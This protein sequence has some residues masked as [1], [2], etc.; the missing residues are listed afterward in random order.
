MLDRKELAA[1]RNKAACAWQESKYA[2]SPDPELEKWW[3]QLSVTAEKIYFRLLEGKAQ[4]SP[5]T[6]IWYV[7]GEAV[8]MPNVCLQRKNDAEV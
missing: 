5:S 4:E 2:G 8:E 1:I 6:T 7:A 3:S